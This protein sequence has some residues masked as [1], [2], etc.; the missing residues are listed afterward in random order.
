MGLGWSEIEIKANSAQLNLVLRLRSAIRALLYSVVHCKL[1]FLQNVDDVLLLLN[2]K[3]TLLITFCFT[4]GLAHVLIG[5]NIKI[6]VNVL[7]YT[8]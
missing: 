1:T 4:T 8:H 5:Y 7:K 6:K 2:V 3:V